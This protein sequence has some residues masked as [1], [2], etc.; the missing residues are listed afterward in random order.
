MT[1]D[2]PTFA[3]AADEARHWKA[4]VDEMRTA[5]LEAENGLQ[6][7]MESSKELEA[8]MEADMAASRQRADT[9]QAE[10]EQL[11][12]DVDE[13]RVRMHSTDLK[14]KYQKSIAEHNAALGDLHTELSKLR[15]TH[16]AYKTRLRDM[17][18]DNDALENA[19]RYVRMLY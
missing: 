8:E 10:N 2:A 14:S 5:L 12:A 15:E 1:G 3:N 9:L 16:D 6:E 4:R 19:E 11:R 7:F 18:L 13:W 17:E